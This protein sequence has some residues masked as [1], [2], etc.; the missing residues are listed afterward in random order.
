M[1]CIASESTT[2]GRFQTSTAWQYGMAQASSHWI[3]RNTSSGRSSQT[4]NFLAGS[5]LSGDLVDRVD[6]CTRKQRVDDQT[7]QDIHPHVEPVLGAE[8]VRHA[9]DLHEWTS[10][11]A[12]PSYNTLD[13]VPSSN[14]LAPQH[15]GPGAELGIILERPHVHAGNATSTPSSAAPAKEPA[16]Q[17]ACHVGTSVTPL[18]RCTPPVLVP[19][20]KRLPE[21]RAP[22]EPRQPTEAPRCRRHQTQNFGELGWRSEWVPRP[23]TAGGGGPRFMCFF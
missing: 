20:S 4:R 12:A 11:D 13:D 19:T 21:P 1:A 14:R 15:H 22:A 7:F 17:S 23:E 18:W 8:Q 6:N 16:P 9:H 10:V 2:D 3:P 5:P